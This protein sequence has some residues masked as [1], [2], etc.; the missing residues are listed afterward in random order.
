MKEQRLA[1]ISG[2][3]LRKSVELLHEL[4]EG[5]EITSEQ[6]E[7][8]EFLLKFLPYAKPKLASVEQKVTVED[9]RVILD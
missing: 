6:K 3:G 8:M 2:G 1:Y 7:G 9:K 5:R 4:L